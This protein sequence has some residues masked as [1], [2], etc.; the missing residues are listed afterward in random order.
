MAGG[1]KKKKKKKSEGR[2]DERTPLARWQAGAGRSSHVLFL[3]FFL[4]PLNELI[5]AFTTRLKGK[6]ASRL[7]LSLGNKPDRMLHFSSVFLFN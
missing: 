7:F 5:K 3:F 1:L 4:S 2:E 6:H